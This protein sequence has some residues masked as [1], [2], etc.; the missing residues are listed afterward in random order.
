MTVIRHPEHDRGEESQMSIRE[1]FVIDVDDKI[2]FRDW[3]LES[4]TL[5]IC[6]VYIITREK[7]KAE[8]SLTLGPRWWK[9]SNSWL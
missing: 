4:E 1:R 7:N 3:S 6:Q 2:R 8:T 9:L 5:Y